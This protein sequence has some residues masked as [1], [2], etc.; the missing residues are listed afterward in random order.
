MQND[1]NIENIKRVRDE[2]ESKRLEQIKSSEI[3]RIKIKDELFKNFCELMNRLKN[4]ENNSYKLSC[5][6]EQWGVWLRS[7]DL[8]DKAK[9]LDTKDVLI[10]LKILNLN[11]RTITRTVQ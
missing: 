5:L 11:Y 10:N 2:A 8:D 6:E 4:I 9:T 7:L 3:E 1:D